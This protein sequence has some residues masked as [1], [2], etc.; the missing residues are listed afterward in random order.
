MGQYFT[1]LF[2]YLF[3]HLFIYLFI[4]LPIHSFVYLLINFCYFVIFTFCCLSSDIPRQL[5]IAIIV[6][7][8]C[9]V[10]FLIYI[11]AS[12]VRISASKVFL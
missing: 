4:Y 9:F 3:I 12:H 11:F 7:I 10:N 5:Y 2:I 8:I 6:S 1:F